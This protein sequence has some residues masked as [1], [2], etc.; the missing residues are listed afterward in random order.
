MIEVG[1][2]QVGFDHLYVFGVEGKLG[3]AVTETNFSGRDAP[4]K[5]DLNT[6]TS[7]AT[8]L[9]RYRGS[10]WDIP[11]NYRGTNPIAKL[12]AEEK[13]VVFAVV[14]F[15]DATFNLKERL[16]QASENG[17]IGGF[18]GVVAVTL[19]RAGTQSMFGSSFQ[20][21]GLASVRR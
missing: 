17:G 5:L 20:R 9:D 11:S 1:S 8:L 12:F 6:V 18:K 3:V 16:I 2:H 7:K 13:D 21:L 14:A 10:L 15:R 19:S 4:T